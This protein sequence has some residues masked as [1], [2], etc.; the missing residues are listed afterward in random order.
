MPTE[1]AGRG[2]AAPP[3]PRHPFAAVLRTVARGPTLSRPLDE[4]EAEAA[5]GMILD[6]AVEPMQLGAFLLLLRYRGETAAELAGFVARR[7]RRGS[8]DRA[9]ERRP[10]LAVLRRRHK[11]LPY[12]LL[13]A[14]LLARNGYRVLM[15]GL[16][17][18]GPARPRATGS[19]RW[20]WRRRARRPR[21]RPGSPPRT[22]PICRSR[23]C[24]RAGR[25]LG[26]KPLLG[27]RTFANTMARELNPFQRPCQIQG[28]STRP[29]SSC[30][31]DAAPARPAARP[32]SRAGAERGSAIPRSPAVCSTGCRFLNSRVLGAGGGGHGP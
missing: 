29:T 30:T 16:A 31:G 4:D 3:E 8:D 22:S 15:H 20:A 28:C 1:P 5:M 2:A 14:L 27:L 6:G 23:R 26:L 7:P 18:E 10:R 11:Q 9:V 19:R 32:P 13:A 21:R 12:F 25:L 17:G 24:C